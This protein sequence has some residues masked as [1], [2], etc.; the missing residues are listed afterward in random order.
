MCSKLEPVALFR[1]TST[2]V[3]LIDLNLRKLGSRHK[4]HCSLKSALL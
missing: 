2:D 4:V 1:E 3:V